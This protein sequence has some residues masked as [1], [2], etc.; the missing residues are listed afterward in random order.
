MTVISSSTYS[1]TIPEHAV[2]GFVGVGP[3]AG[4]RRDA[5]VRVCGGARVRVV[6]GAQRAGR[7]AARAPHAAAHGPLALAA[8]AAHALTARLAQRHTRL[9]T[10]PATTSHS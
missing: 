8:G 9:F 6:G 2:R 7:G 5:R 1:A 4:R 10:P 3:F